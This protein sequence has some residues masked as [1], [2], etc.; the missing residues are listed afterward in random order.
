MRSAIQSDI[1][2]MNSR[3]LFDLFRQHRRLT[4]TDVAG[5]LNMTVP[6]VLKVTQQLLDNH[7]VQ[8]IGEIDTALGRKP[9][10]FEFNPDFLNAI[11]VSFEGVSLS[12]GLV[13]VD[14]EIRLA[15]RTQLRGGIDEDFARSVI[16]GV[17]RIKRQSR[18]GALSGVGIAIPG[19]VN[20][21]AS[22]IEFAPLIGIKEPLDVSAVVKRIS[23]QLGLQVILENDVNMYA[24][25]ETYARG[26]GQEDDLLCITLGTG[27]GC[28][29][30]LDGK[31]H[32]GRNN[33]CGEMGYFVNGAD[34]V[35]HRDRQ[36]YLES[37]INIKTLEERFSF[38]AGEGSY[39]P[40]MI[41]YISSVL[42]PHIANIT[43][44]L[45]IRTVVLG[46]MVADLCGEALT[47]TVSSD[48]NRL[49]LSPIRVERSV[50]DDPGVVG[51]AAMIIERRVE[52]YL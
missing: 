21:A 28:G 51:A 36:G 10:Q 43:T 20:P 50:S 18:P 29:I 2:K 16:N 38:D 8:E 37:Q 22:I 44:L 23:N 13:N 46:G 9:K 3:L 11:G 25:G 5:Y 34:Y 48:V 4:R 40:E 42:S 6:S 19:I 17:E 45:D 47:E 27:I 39:P 24:K 49:A 12:M 41:P 26:L 14:G 7:V 35:T 30:I 15:T 32:R 31:L 52:E 33:L 1:R